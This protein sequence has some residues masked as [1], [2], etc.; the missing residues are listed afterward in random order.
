MKLEG[1]K[2]TIP[3]QLLVGQFT[4]RAHSGDK[5]LADLPI[6]IRPPQLELSDLIEVQPP[7]ELNN[8]YILLPDE[9]KIALKEK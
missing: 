9:S 3:A 7:L 2:V 5:V 8:K 6:E 1:N 4:L